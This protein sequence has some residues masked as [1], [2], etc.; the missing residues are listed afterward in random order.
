MIQQP[1]PYF[2]DQYVTF[3][4]TLGLDDSTETLTVTKPDGTTVSYAH[5]ALTRVANV[6]G[7]VTYSH[8]VKLDQ[9]GQWYGQFSSDSTDAGT[10][11][12]LAYVAL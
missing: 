12:G 8:Q 6:D 4:D 11:I 2:L 7:S 5:N 3:S 9:R 10:V 1:I